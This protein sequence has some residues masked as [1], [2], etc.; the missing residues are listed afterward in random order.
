MRDYPS[1]DDI[2]ERFLLLRLA[3][4]QN[5]TFMAELIGVSQTS[6]SKYELGERTPNYWNLREIHRRTGCPPE[7]LM[8]GNVS[9]MPAN[10]LTDIERH[11]KNGRA[12]E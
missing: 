1:P 11:R 6:W 10:L 2:A 4:G 9:R 3:L 7:W 12:L 8:E 5:Q